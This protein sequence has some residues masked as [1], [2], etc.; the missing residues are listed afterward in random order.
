MKQL[1]RLVVLL[2]FYQLFSMYSHMVFSN[3]L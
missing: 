2:E 1:P 3:L